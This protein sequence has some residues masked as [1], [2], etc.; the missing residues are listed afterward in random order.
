MPKNNGVHHEIAVKDILPF[1]KSSKC[2]N[3][4]VIHDRNVNSSAN[5]AIK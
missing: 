1:S 5:G 2:K 3:G 4:V